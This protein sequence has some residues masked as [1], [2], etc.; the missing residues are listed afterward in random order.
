MGPSCVGAQ[1]N[2][3]VCRA[4]RRRQSS[5]VCDVEPFHQTSGSA[6]NGRHAL[7]VDAD[8]SV[9][10]INKISLRTGIDDGNKRGIRTKVEQARL[11]TAAPTG[12]M[13]P[14]FV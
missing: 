5:C 13:H 10:A 8:Q 11:S 4:W 12:G 3:S 2:V 7:C 9:A 6:A 14:W 1:S